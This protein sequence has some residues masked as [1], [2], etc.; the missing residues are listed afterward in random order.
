MKISPLGFKHSETW[1]VTEEQI[2]QI[3]TFVNRR[4]RKFM[5]IWCPDTIYN[6]DL[7]QYT[8]QKRIHYEIHEG[9][10]RWIGHILKWDTENR[11]RQVLDW[12][13]QGRR[14]VRW[15]K[16]TWRWTVENEA[17]HVGKS[18]NKITRLT[19]KSYLMV[20]LKTLL[21]SCRIFIY[22]PYDLLVLTIL[23]T[24]NYENEKEA[25]I[26]FSMYFVKLCT[27]S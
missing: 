8:G 2:S 15:P 23:H 16:N 19:T 3:Q 18:L 22:H 11:T 9:K 17:Q 24:L 4:L 20:F 5:G 12:N 7:W 26:T 27:T 1:K 25:V 14:R 13:V 21:E 10:W 6:K